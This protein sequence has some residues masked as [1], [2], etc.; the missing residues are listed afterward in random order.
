MSRNKTGTKANRAEKNRAFQAQLREQRRLRKERREA[1]G[2]MTLKEQT[3]DRRFHRDELAKVGIHAT[4]DLLPQQTFDE[5]TAA[6]HSLADDP[7]LNGTATDEFFGTCPTQ[8]EWDEMHDRAKRRK[9]GFQKFA[10]N[11]GWK[12]V[13]EDPKEKDHWEIPR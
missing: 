7:I 5:L 8:K 10:E 9:R 13:G 4:T 3:E 12:L 11:N 1:H 2:V 6:S